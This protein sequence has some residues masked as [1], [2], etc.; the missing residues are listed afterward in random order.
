MTKKFYVCSYGG[1]GSKM[2]CTALTEYGESIHIHSR[3]PP[4]KLEYCG[5]RNG[6]KTYTEWFNGMVIP[7]NE[8]KDYYVIYIYRNPSFSIPSRFE[9]PKHLENIQTDKTIKL[10][11]VL[12][13]GKDLYKIRDFYDN[14]MKPNEKRNYKIY[15]IK[16]EDIFDKQD[17]LS[18]LFGIGKLK[19]VNKSTRNHSNTQLDEIYADLIDE[20]SRNDFIII[21]PMLREN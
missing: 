5:A 1:S 18:N 3:K 7:E 20:M 4:D 12:S 10:D 16:Y 21:N 13:S 19:M 11:D 6:G 2:L 15:C 17:E 9:R 8:L 14:Y